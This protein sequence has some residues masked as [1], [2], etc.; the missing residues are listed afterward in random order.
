MAPNLQKL[1]MDGAFEE[2]KT[3]AQDTAPIKLRNAARSLCDAFK[4]FL[5]EL[6][7]VIYGYDFI[8][9]LS[10]KIRFAFI[11]QHIPELK[12]YDDFAEKLDKLRNKIEHSDTFFP[13]KE[14]LDP[15]IPRAGSLFGQLGSLIAK[16]K[17]Q[18]ALVDLKAQRRLLVFFLKWL[19]DEFQGY[20]QCHRS[21]GREPPD[22]DVKKVEEL[23]SMRSEL[24]DMSLDNINDAL[25]D[26]RQVISEI[27]DSWSELSDAIEAYHL[28]CES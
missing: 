5:D 14:R 15:L 1:T 9:K 28:S 10:T 3:L 18:D 4:L 2:A 27:D 16:I 24:D 21:F 26:V 12:P 8:S 22:E 17:S 19:E 25:I 23:L 11:R 7:S 20:A 6:G 13:T